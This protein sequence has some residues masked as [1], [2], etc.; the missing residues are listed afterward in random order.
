GKPIRVAVVTDPGGLGTSPQVAAGVQS[1]ARALADAGYAVEEVDPPQ[2]LEAAQ[3]WLDLLATEIHLM[4][5][6]MQP[7]ASDGANLF[8]GT[9]LGA[10]PMADLATYV[11]SLIARSAILRAWGEFQQRYPVIVGPVCTEPPFTVGTDLTADGIE[12]IRVAMRFVVAVN[13]LG[14][15]P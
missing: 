6:Q 11:Q 10:H 14:V 7:I 2:I 1:A 5:P 8:M 9:F 15:P 4:W 12:Q 3:A 13:R